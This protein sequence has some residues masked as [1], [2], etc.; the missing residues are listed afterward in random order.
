MASN[1]IMIRGAEYARRMER[2]ATAAVITPGQILSLNSDDK[3]LRHATAGG[4]FTRLVAVE[5]ENQ[6]RGI[7]TDYAASSRVQFNVVKPGDVIN[8]LVAD[9][10][11][12]SIGDEIES[13]GDGDVREVTG[14][15]GGTA[16]GS[17]IGIALEA[18]DLSDS[19]GADPSSRRCAVLVL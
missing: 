7:D 3:V 6:G 8:A 14:D 5:D 19:S 12:I 16:E 2:L 17:I 4:R 18:L 9:G 13:N 15:S 1:T 10:E 11:D